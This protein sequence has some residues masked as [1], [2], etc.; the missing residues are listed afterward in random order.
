MRLVLLSIALLSA[1]CA[2]A[3]SQ[4]GAP[5]A[6]ASASAGQRADLD[7]RA[8]AERHQAGVRLI[9]VRSDREFQS[10]RIPGAL[11]VPMSRVSPD[12]PA[13]AAHPKDQP[14]YVVCEVGG[15]SSHVADQLARAG[16]RVVNVSGG[17]AAWNR[18]G[19]PLEN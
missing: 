10:G 8:F 6:E 5:S 7:V 4:G 9:D 12:H 11:H 14:L 1:A 19:L 18:A 16:Y 3:F 17:T 2:P 13:I 15:R